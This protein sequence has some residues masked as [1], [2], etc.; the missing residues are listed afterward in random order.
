MQ[1]ED[2]GIEQGL[3]IGVRE[4]LVVGVLLNKEG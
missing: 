2:C 1:G 4:I 3:P